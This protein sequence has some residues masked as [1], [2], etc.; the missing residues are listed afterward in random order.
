M[1]VPLSAQSLHFITMSESIRMDEIFGF[2]FLIVIVVK[3]NLADS[4]LE[5]IVY[6]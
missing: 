1:K 2:A 3:F 4:V 6:S 5:V